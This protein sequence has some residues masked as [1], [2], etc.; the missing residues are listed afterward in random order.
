[1]FQSIPLLFMLGE[2]KMKVKVKVKSLSCVRLFATPRTVAC[3]AP[4]SME[5]SRHEYWS[6][7][8]F[9][10]PGESSWPRD[11]IRFLHCRQ[12]LYQLSYQEERKG[13]A[14]LFF[15]VYKVSVVQNE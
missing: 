9:P 2:I 5:F 14:K 7:Y 15:N 12:I 11:Q 6:G 3:Q 8:P 10:S 4:M 13:N 1:M